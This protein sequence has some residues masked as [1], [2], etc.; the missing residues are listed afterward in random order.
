MLRRE[1]LLA[2]WEVF[3]VPSSAWLLVLKPA[4]PAHHRLRHLQPP[5]S[6]GPSAVIGLLLVFLLALTCSGSLT[7]A[8]STRW[9]KPSSHGCLVA[10]ISSNRTLPAWLLCASRSRVWPP[11][12][13][14]L[15]GFRREAT[16]S[17]GG[18]TCQTRPRGLVAP[19]QMQQ[20]CPLGSGLA[21]SRPP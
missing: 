13:S 4:R 16:L 3:R 12:R 5:F 9:C 11:P 18:S 6:G 17:R 15:R 8:L 10:L 14:T 1:A 7:M 19:C 21:A 2:A 20:S